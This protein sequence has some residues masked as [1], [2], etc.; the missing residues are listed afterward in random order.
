VRSDPAYLKAQS[1]VNKRV[2]SPGNHPGHSARAR[3]LL[4]GRVWSSAAEAIHQEAGWAGE[5]MGEGQWAL[6]AADDSE[7]QLSLQRELA[8]LAERLLTVRSGRDCLRAIEDRRI[9]FVVLDSSLPDVSGTHLVHLVQQIRPD[10]GVI[11]TFAQ[12]D[13]AQECEARQAGV[14]FYGD[15]SEARDIASVLRKG[16]GAPGTNGARGCGGV[17]EVPPSWGSGS[18]HVR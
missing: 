9:R 14:L 8:G 13:Q 12:S 4:N 18:P 6:V 11:L 15:R 10:L 5:G 3:S 2:V 7:F 16:M 17:R 1:I